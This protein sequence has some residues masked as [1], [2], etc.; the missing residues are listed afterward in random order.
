MK[1]DLISAWNDSGGGYLTRLLDGALDTQV[2]PYE[3]LLG[4]DDIKDGFEGWF[5]SCYRWPGFGD[6]TI[7]IN[8]AAEFFDKTQD[9]E[10]KSVLREGAASKHADFAIELD[11]GEWR[12]DFLSKI[13]SLSS[14]RR[15]DLLPAYIS[16]VR[17]AVWA[18]DGEDKRVIGH[19]P[20]II[21]DAVKIWK[22]QPQ[23]KFLHIVRNP[24]NCF[25]D[26]SQRHKGVD[27]CRYALK[28]KT[29]NDYALTLAKLFPHSVKLVSLPA[30]LLE[31]ADIMQ[32]LCGWL[33]VN[34]DERVL[35]PT[36]LSCPLNHRKMGPFGG[37]PEVSIDRERDLFNKHALEH[38]KILQLCAGSLKAFQDFGF[39]L[40]GQ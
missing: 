24:A 28:W 27:P 10:I 4:N 30:L 15:A 8:E 32:S 29:V 23:L 3:L 13:A 35:E 7:T 12:D 9:P 33:E 18:D 21:L 1:L 6:Q 25:M 38:E 39:D 36:W 31:K 16:P 26:F 22:E 34:F 14:I 11:I 20:V 17:H 40:T 19:C 5:K 2:W 37:V